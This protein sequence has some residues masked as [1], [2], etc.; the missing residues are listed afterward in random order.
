MCSSVFWLQLGLVALQGGST[1]SFYAQVPAPWRAPEIK[2]RLHKPLDWKKKKRVTYWATY[3]VCSTAHRPWGHRA[4]P[5]ALPA[6]QSWTC[7]WTWDPGDNNAIFWLPS[8][9]WWGDSHELC[10]WHSIWCAARLNTCDMPWWQILKPIPLLLAIK[11]WKAF[12]W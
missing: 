3:S 7:L 1:F 10:G 2:L 6:E 9:D 11:K 5:P 12:I 8:E 4:S